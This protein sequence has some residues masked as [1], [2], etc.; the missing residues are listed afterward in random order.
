MSIPLR[1][2]S[3]LAPV[4]FDTYLGYF[5]SP[6]I[7]F[8]IISCLSKGTWCL[9][10]VS[11]RNKPYLGRLARRVWAVLLSGGTIQ[12]LQRL[13]DI[14]GWVEQQIQDFLASTW[15][16]SLY[17]C[18]SKCKLC[19]H[20]CRFCDILCYSTLV[21]RYPIQILDAHFFWFDKSWWR[22]VG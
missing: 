4:S 9:R 13:S 1:I 6:G 11:W 14:H 19:T 2:N 12:S 15:P 10:C 7:S 3:H 18:Q 16:Q 8:L 5:R 21:S 22:A 17:R 20:A